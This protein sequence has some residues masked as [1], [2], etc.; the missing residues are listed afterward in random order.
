MPMKFPLLLCLTLLSGCVAVQRVGMEIL[1]EKAS[2]P[3]AQITRDIP[4]VADSPSPS[5]ALIFSGL[6]RIA[7][8]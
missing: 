1:Y 8:P 4:Y 5:T 6:P 2:L 7:G 3:A